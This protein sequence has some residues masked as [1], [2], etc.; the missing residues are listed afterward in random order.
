VDVD[1]DSLNLDLHINPDG[2]QNWMT[3]ELKLITSGLPF[4]L[5]RVN[6]AN[7]QFLLT[8]HA[9]SEILEF[10]LEHFLVDLGQGE[11]RAEINSS[12]SFDDYRFL[13]SGGAGFDIE[14]RVLDL[15][16]AFT[17]AQFRKIPDGELP[18]SPKATW[19]EDSISHYPMRGQVRGSITLD[20]ETVYGELAVTSNI[21][22]LEKLIPLPPDFPVLNGTI[23]PIHSSGIIHINGHTV[24]LDIDQVLLENDQISLEATGELGNLLDSIDFNLNLSVDVTD[25]GVIK[26]PDGVIPAEIEAIVKSHR[27]MG[28]ATISGELENFNVSNL[29]FTFSSTDRELALSG[30][31]SQLPANP[32]GDLKIT[33]MIADLEKIIQLPAESPTITGVIGPIKAKGV[34]RFNEGTM[35]LDDIDALLEND[36]LVLE[37]TGDIHNLMENPVFDLNLSAD[38]HDLGTIALAGGI[39]PEEFETFIK[40]HRGTGNA[41]LTGNPADFNIGN[42]SVTISDDNERFSFSGNVSQL[43]T[44]PETGVEVVFTSDKPFQLD[45]ILPELEKFQTAAPVEIK[46]SINYFD[47]HLNFQNLV[48]QLGRQMCRVTFW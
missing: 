30:Q 14:K 39:V 22:N 42:L 20:Q 34:V 43:L 24:D 28:N 17:A 26:L 21:Q 48:V 3:E 23:G 12:G 16:I 6:A 10:A 25:L 8:N 37:A 9:E 32:S 41:T 19:F 2:S 47:Q 44:N 4:D 29:E 36:Q 7:T 46:G 35:N 40:D 11:A 15:D 33:A 38:I 27:G 1:I 13:A 31:I 18:V 45:R 5:D